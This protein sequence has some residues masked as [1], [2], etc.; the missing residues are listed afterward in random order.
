RLLHGRMVCGPRRVAEPLRR[1]D[2]SLRLWQVHRVSLQ[3]AG[4]CCAAHLFLLAATSH[5][6]WLV[7]LTPSVWK[8]L[9]MALF[10]ASGLIVLHVA[11]GVMQYDHNPFIPVMLASSF[12]WVA[13]L[14][15]V[16]GWRERAGDQTGA[17]GSDGWLP[18]GPPLSIPDKGARI[19]AA[20]NDG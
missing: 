9:H 17:S 20:P 2:Q 6:Y 16:A 13:V 5:D 3:G 7:F 19:V 12:G 18:V 15:L 8:G 11:L 10:F 4:P 14:H 1:T